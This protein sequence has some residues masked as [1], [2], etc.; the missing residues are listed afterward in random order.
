MNTFIFFKQHGDRQYPPPP[1]KSAG[2]FLCKC[3]IWSY[4]HI[5]KTAS[6]FEA[7]CHAQEK[8]SFNN[9]KILSWDLQVTV[10]T[11]VPPCMRHQSERS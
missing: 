6:S 10:A 8:K 7:G 5:L 1:K 3:V 4:Y 11:V 9:P 2:F